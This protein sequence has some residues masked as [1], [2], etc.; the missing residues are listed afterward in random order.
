[1]NLP[2]IN[3]ARVYLTEQENLDLDISLT[4][5]ITAYEPYFSAIRQSFDKNMPICG[6]DG[7]TCWSKSLLYCIPLDTTMDNITWS[8][9]SNYP[10]LHLA[11]TPRWPVTG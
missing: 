5:R 6:I 7:E 10:Y 8:I 11:H 4:T 3:F 1:M 9:S 2:T